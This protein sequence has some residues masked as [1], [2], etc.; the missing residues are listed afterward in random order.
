MRIRFLLI[1]FLTLAAIPYFRSE[2]RK[3]WTTTTFLDFIDGTFLDGGANT[4][5]TGGGDI[6][7]INV[8]DLNHDGNIDL[9]LPGSQNYV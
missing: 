9:V 4:Y 7:L 6:R 3:Q 1:C 2:T 5:V 8:L